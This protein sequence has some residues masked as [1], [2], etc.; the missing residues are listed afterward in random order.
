MKPEEPRELLTDAL[1]SAL[2]ASPGSDLPEGFDQ[3]FRARLAEAEGREAL[4]PALWETL[5]EAREPAPANRG[6][7]VGW[8]VAI[9]AAASLLVAPLVW[10]RSPPDDDLQLVAELALVEG[11]DLLQNPDFEFIVAWDGV[12]P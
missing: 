9:A 3:G 4:G 10:N 6:S 7:W 2:E 8:A 12:T 5:G 11:I 1:W